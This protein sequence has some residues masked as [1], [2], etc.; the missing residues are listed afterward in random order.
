ML[1]QLVA[2]SKETNENL[3]KSKKTR[4]L[5]LVYSI[6]NFN[7]EDIKGTAFFQVKLQKIEK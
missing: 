7:Y 6:Q 4:A 1:T 5:R 2:H 3:G